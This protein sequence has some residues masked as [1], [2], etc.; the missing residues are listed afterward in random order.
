[1]ISDRQ[2]EYRQ[3]YLAEIGPAY[4]GWVHVLV[5]YGVSLGA[6]AGCL[7]RLEGAAWEWL[8]VLPVAIGANFAEWA[9]HK[10]LLHRLV[11]VFGLRLAYDRHTRQHHRYFTY[12][13]GTFTT[14]REFR[15]VFFPWRVLVALVLAGGLLAL[16]FALLLNANAGYIVFATLMSHYVLYETFH[17]CCH[18]PE[19]PW[20]RR[21]PLINTMRRNHAAHHDPDLMMECNLNLTLPIADWALGTSDLDRGLFGHLFNGYGETHVKP[22]LKRRAKENANTVGSSLS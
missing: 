19:N 10:Y 22:S 4:S 1:M 5:L 14:V 16:A 17:A 6:I 2:R 9:I 11:D 12:D 15:I 13:E 20:M 18:V 3:Q 21:L 8:L 7:T